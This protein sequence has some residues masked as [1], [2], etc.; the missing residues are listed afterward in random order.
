MKDFVGVKH[1]RAKAMTRG[2]YNALR[3]WEVPANENPAD[4]GFLVEYIDGGQANHPDFQGYIS[5]SPQDVF[6]RAYFPTT[7][8]NFA[9]A[10]A[11]MQAGLKVRRADDLENNTRWLFKYIC[12]DRDGFSVAP[13]SGVDKQCKPDYADWFTANDWEVY[14]EP[15]NT[16]RLEDAAK[17]LEEVRANLEQGHA[18]IDPDILRQEGDA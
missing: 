11:A 13:R 18:T 7:G 4:A 3:G 5:W 16:A 2:E 6:E 8:M 9:Q 15:V 14:Q 1:I 10:V 12:F 17:K